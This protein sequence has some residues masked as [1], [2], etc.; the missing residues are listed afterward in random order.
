MYIRGMAAD[1]DAWRDA[2][3]P[4]WGYGVSCLIFVAPI[5]VTPLKWHPQLYPSVV[6][7]ASTLGKCDVQALRTGSL[8]TV[9]SARRSVFSSALAVISRW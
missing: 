1:Y 2:G 3:L 4:G 7:A 9:T 5:S 6:A 8:I